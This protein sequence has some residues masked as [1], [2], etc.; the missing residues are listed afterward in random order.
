MSSVRRRLFFGFDLT[1]SWL[2]SVAITGWGE[3]LLKARFPFNHHFPPW[4]SKSDLLEPIASSLEAFIKAC[5]ADTVCSTCVDSPALT[6]LAK[7]LDAPLQT[8][9]SLD[10]DEFRLSGYDPLVRKE[11]GLDP[12]YRATLAALSS[13]IPQEIF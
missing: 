2:F 3:V 10:F 4:E 13:A 1:D 11:L 5:N 8:I 6:T 9:R 12:Y 7:R